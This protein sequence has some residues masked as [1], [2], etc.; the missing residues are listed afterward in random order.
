[1]TAETNTRRKPMRFSAEWWAFW[2]GVWVVGL[3]VAAA[4]TGLIAWYFSNQASDEKDAR[5]AIFQDESRTAVASAEARAAEARQR[6][7][8]A[9]QG[10]AHALENAASATERTKKFELAA[11]EQRERA[12]K[13]EKDLLEVQQRLAWRT[14]TAEQEAILVGVLSSFKGQAV[15]LFV[16]SG[17]EEISRFSRQLQAALEKAGLVVSRN[18]GQL[19]GAAS[20]GL[21]ADIG[22][23]RLDIGNAMGMALFR[24]KLVSGPLPAN[25][26]PNSALLRLVVWPK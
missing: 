22:D 3:T 11:E 25:K 6:A 5:L 7:A 26:I 16:I 21:S 15:T 8:N 4:I 20:S 14:V 1:M 2:A 17:S 10:A 9:E 13:A 23:G 12:A 19:F 18:D 24:A